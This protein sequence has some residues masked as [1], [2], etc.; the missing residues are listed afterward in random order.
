MTAI[1]RWAAEQAS[2]IT[3][4]VFGP[5]P[6]TPIALAAHFPIEDIDTYMASR[7]GLIDL[8]RYC[9]SMELG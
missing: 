5:H 3:L 6:A 2:R 4:P 9:P 8:A 7:V 1:L